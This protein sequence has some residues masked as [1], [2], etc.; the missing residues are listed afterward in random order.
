M[1]KNNNKR[2]KTKNNFKRRILELNKLKIYRGAKLEDSFNSLIFN[3]CTRVYKEVYN[4][5]CGFVLALTVSR[6]N[7]R[8]MSVE[9][10][11]G[12]VSN[13]LREVLLA[14]KESHLVCGLLVGVEMYGKYRGRPNSRAL[15]PHMHLA[16]FCYNDFLNLPLH[17][18]EGRLR[19][20]ELDYRVTKLKSGRDSAR[21]LGYCIKSRNDALLQRITKEVLGGPSVSLFNVKEMSIPSMVN[22]GEAIGV[23]VIAE[24]LNSGKGI[25]SC[26]RELDSGL[27][28][29][30]YVKA[31]CLHSGIG[32]FK[33]V[34]CIRKKNA[35][36]TWSQHSSVPDFVTQLTEMQAEASFL[37]HLKNAGALRGDQ[38]LLGTDTALKV[39]PEIVYKTYCWE[40]K[41][42]MVYQGQEGRLIEGSLLMDRFISCGKYYDFDFDELP[43][44]IKLLNV[45]AQ[46][47]ETSEMRKF[48]LRFAG[49]WH[50]LG[51][52]GFK[53]KDL[54]ALLIYGEPNSLKTTLVYK[55]LCMSLEDVLI[56]EV[57]QYGE[58][59]GSGRFSFSL[60][61]D[62]S[63]GVVFVDDIKSSSGILKYPGRLTNF[64]DGK[65]TVERKYEAP[66]LQDYKGGAVFTSNYNTQELLVG[67]DKYA[68]EDYNSLKERISEVHFVKPVDA[69]KLSKEIESLSDKEV[70]GFVVFCNT[71]FLKVR[72]DIEGRTPLSWEL[73]GGP[74]EKE[75]PHDSNVVSKE[76]VGSLG[77]I[78]KL[79][80]NYIWTG[81][82]ALPE[83]PKRPPCKD[84]QNENPYLLEA[85]PR[86]EKKRLRKKGFSIR[87]CK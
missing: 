30:S 25:I 20:L 41:G 33:K 77:F 63:V 9:E 27:Q 10:S 21:W 7:L 56:H 75:E 35:L 28:A 59:S 48:L 73:N 81:K 17:R 62:V 11:W 4:D 70:G 80:S 69:Q 84:S 71:L 82:L 61:K 46:V 44:P 15:K 37:Y 54:R 47:C 34:L 2:N 3:D 29:G 83:M 5:H 42:G 60:L 53:R 76:P 1:H 57:G 55:I 36:F 22:L 23:N 40:F 58:G 74:A 43:K 45:L 72:F 65:M 85:T 86:G 24:A 31:Q 66:A 51:V 50:E 52:Y 16:V 78:Y 87:R 6:L 13:L 38:G 32:I 68:V 14:I 49:L 39:Y 19:G 12:D 67:N 18:L 26:R 64:L 79:V 8:D